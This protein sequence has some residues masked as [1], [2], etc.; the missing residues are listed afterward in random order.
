VITFAVRRLVLGALLLAVVSFLSWLVF[1]PAIN[2]LWRYFGE[3]NSP[4]VVAMAKQA[5]LHDPL[6]VRYGLWAK[7]LFTGQGFGRTVVDHAP[8]GTELRIAFEH[9]CELI[10]FSLVIIVVASVLVAAVEARRRDSAVDVG[11]RATSYFV[12]SIPAFLLSLLVI[13]AVAAAPA[14]WHLFGLVQGGS[15]TGPGDFFQ[16]MTLPALVLA[17]GFVGAYSRYLR[18][19][20]LVAL[21]EPYAWVARGKGLTER[22]VVRRHA[23]RNALVP[24]T[25]VIALDFGA[26][27]GASIAV[28]YVFNLGGLASLVL[29]GINI[30]DPFVIEAAI[31]VTAAIVVVVGIVADLVCGWLDPRIRLA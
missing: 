17:V 5:H 6:L 15:P 16:R 8:I 12:W 26:V 29:Y 10:G 19:S 1:V 27:F 23:L 20:L 24:F 30:A 2:P 31:V 13:H 3:P 14:S 9:T 21:Q 4:F 25:T 18:S 7:G 28:D 11:L 22:E